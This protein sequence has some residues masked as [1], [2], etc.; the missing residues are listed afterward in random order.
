MKTGSF[1]GITLL[2]MAL[3][4]GY[5]HC[6]QSDVISQAQEIGTVPATSNTVANPVPEASAPV[7]VLS[8]PKPAPVKQIATHL[9]L[10]TTARRVHHRH[11]RN[12]PNDIR[13]TEVVKAPPAAD[14]NVNNSASEGLSKPGSAPQPENRPDKV[15]LMNRAAKSTASRHAPEPITMATVARTV[16]SL[17]FVLVLAYLVIAGIKVLSNRN[18]VAPNR[19]GDIR[20]MDTVHLSQGNSIHLI[21]VRGKVLLIA[22]ST[23]RISLL[24]QMDPEPES[25]G[26]QKDNNQFAEYLA[27]YSKNGSGDGTTTR[28]SGLVRDCADYLRQRHAR[29]GASKRSDFRNDDES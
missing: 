19:M 9:S 24:D 20:I 22:S 10:I 29:S 17:G 25:V 8:K 6:A 21:N 23:G 16:L 18:G 2:L 12:K 26:A 3:F 27:R 14:K 1:I 28:I 15:A 4:F 5:G 13:V 7:A 11:R